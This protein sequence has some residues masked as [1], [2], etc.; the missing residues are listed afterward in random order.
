MLDK[1][2]YPG[3]K[4]LQFAFDGKNSDYLPHNHIKNCV[5]YTGTH[6]ND[7]TCGWYKTAS[8]QAKKTFSEYFESVKSENPQDILI[9]SAFASCAD[10]VIIPMQDYLG[11]DSNARMNTPSTLGGNWEWRIDSKLLNATL[12]DKILHLTQIYCR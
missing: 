12:S 2:G 6:D 3:L 10:T 7:T 1:T 8:K 9:R 4:I 11:L 5:V